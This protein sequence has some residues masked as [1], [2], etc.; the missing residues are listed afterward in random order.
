MLTGDYHELLAWDPENEVEVTCSLMFV[1]LTC[2]MKLTTLFVGR[3]VISKEGECSTR[4]REA[5]FSRV[6]PS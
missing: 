5:D 4:R 6:L 2:E 1:F 3:K